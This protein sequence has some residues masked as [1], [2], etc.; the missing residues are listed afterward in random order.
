VCQPTSYKSVDAAGNCG[1]GEKVSFGRRGMNK[2][3]RRTEDLVAKLR[4]DREAFAGVVA[5]A[6][7]DVVATADVELRELFE[8]LDNLI[9]EGERHRDFWVGS[10]HGDYPENPSVA[11]AI[12]RDWNAWTRSALALHLSSGGGGSSIAGNRT[13]YP[14]GGTTR[15]AR[16][17]HPSRS[18]LGSAWVGSCIGGEARSNV[19]SPE[20]R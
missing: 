14:C 9:N 7:P 12:K 10:A 6:D 2:N 3:I 15:V 16:S 20:A 8:R 1:C 4:D 11:R 5:A 17:C 18:K 13:A 19:A